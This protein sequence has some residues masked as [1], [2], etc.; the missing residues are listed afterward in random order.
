MYSIDSELKH[1]SVQARERN[2][3][4][5]KRLELKERR[6]ALHKKQFERDAEEGLVSTDL[7][8][9]LMSNSARK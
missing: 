7:L 1:L 5:F 8:R 9:I 2:A 6:L 3:N 4:E